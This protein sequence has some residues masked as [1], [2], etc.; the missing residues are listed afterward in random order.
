MSKRK[1]LPF[2]GL[3]ITLMIIW[4]IT[5]TYWIFVVPYKD[6]GAIVYWPV[7]FTIGIFMVISARYLNNRTE[8]NTDYSFSVAVLIG[9]SAG[10]G[11]IWNYLLSIYLGLDPVPVTYL[12]S[13]SVPAA[14]V[15]VDQ[16]HRTIASA[17]VA[18][19]QS[20]TGTTATPTN[21]SDTPSQIKYLNR[22]DLIAIGTAIVGVTLVSN[23]IVG[24]VAGSFVGLVSSSMLQY[25]W[26]RLNSME[27]NHTSNSEG[28]SQTGETDSNFPTAE[29][30]R[31]AAE[32]A[33]EKAVTAIS[34]DD[35]TTATTAYR[36]AINRYQAALEALDAGAASERTEIEETIEATRE[37]LETVKTR[38]EQQSAVIDDLG[39]AERS[40]Q[41]AIVAYIQNDQTIARIRFR[42]ARDAFED[43]HQTIAGSEDD[44]L[45][46]PI[47][48]SIQPDRELS[49][50]TLSDLSTIP[51]PAATALADA[52]IEA[53]GDLDSKAE[54]P[55][56]PAT[57]EDLTADDIITGEITPTLTLLSWW[58]GDDSCTFDTV[59]V[60]KSRQQQADYGFN[61]TS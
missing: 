28:I 40:L 32:N 3:V 25:S 13:G 58:H 21:P 8:F 56:T 39:S 42:Q 15:F 18:T 29:E 47:E 49:S 35:F 59:E 53:V 34:N 57:V 26:D 41:E 4:T 6:V 17:L 11:A 46:E 38:H 61:H 10:L 27:G 5:I 2:N 30:H 37:E 7:L 16:I 52:G 1:L 9:F 60:I 55:W 31:I 43:A 44:L 50:A 24:T 19:N 51:E 14:F 23:P 33:I 45:T 22:K 48:V 12:I 20:V 54:S 36:D